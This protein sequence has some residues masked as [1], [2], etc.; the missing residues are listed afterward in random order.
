MKIMKIFRMKYLKTYN[1]K[2]IEYQY[3]NI[4]IINIEG[5]DV[6]YIDILNHFTTDNYLKKILDSNTILAGKPYKE[7]KHKVVSLTRNC[8]IPNTLKNLNFGCRI[9]LNSSELGK[10]FDINPYLF[11]PKEKDFSWECKDEMEERIIG[12]I[13][14]LD[15]Y[16]VSID[17]INNNTYNF[18]KNKYPNLKINKVSK[19]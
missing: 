5:K 17:I 14:N 3:K 15:K 8:K 10:D 2:N 11:I 18:I 1:E 19:L 9:G 13:N 12:D 6:K 16:I 4:V 7:E